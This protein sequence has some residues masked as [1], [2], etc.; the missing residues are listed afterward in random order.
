MSSPGQ[1]RGGYGHVMASLDSH[2]F[3]ARCRDKGKGKGPCIEKPDTTYCKSCNSLTEEQRCQLATPSYQIK[4]EKRET[5]TM[6]AF[7]IPNKDSSSA[8]IDPAT[9]SALGAV[10][11]QGDLQSPSGSEPYTYKPKKVYLFQNQI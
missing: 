4:K 9:V 1:K 5:K 10:N 7:S 8:L 2:S 6:E 11:V 3:C